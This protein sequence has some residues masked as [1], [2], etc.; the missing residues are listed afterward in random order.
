MSFQQKSGSRIAAFRRHWNDYEWLIWTDS[1]VLLTNPGK[2]LEAIVDKYAPED[3][4]AHEVTAKR[5]STIQ[6]L[7]LYWLL[8]ANFGPTVFA[9]CISFRYPRADVEGLGRP[10]GQSWCDVS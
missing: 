1:D 4:G 7:Q 2:K 9:S 8:T 5:D 3:S 6:L 10:P